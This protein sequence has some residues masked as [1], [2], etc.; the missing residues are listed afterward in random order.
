[1]IGEVAQPWLQTGF[2]LA[3]L[4]KGIK[5]PSFARRRYP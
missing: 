2:L 3:I 4:I 1:M 5:M